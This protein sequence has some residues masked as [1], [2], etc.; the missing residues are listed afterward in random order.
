MLA[1]LRF[2]KLLPGTFILLEF[3]PALLCAMAALP[4]LIIE[5]SS[6]GRI[7]LG[8]IFPGLVLIFLMFVSIRSALKGYP[9]TI[10]LEF[11][12]SLWI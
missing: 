5:Q 4:V 11:H 2:P 6:T 10:K 3:G 12:K 7:W 1:L 8:G 9:D